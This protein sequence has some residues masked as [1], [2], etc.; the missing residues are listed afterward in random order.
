MPN[1]ESVHQL[2]KRYL[3]NV[4]QVGYE[5]NCTRVG[6]IEALWSSWGKNTQGKGLINRV[7]T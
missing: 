6:K 2:D 3:L 7:L 1:R 5:H 4:A